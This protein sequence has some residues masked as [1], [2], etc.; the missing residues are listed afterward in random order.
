VSPIVLYTAHLI[1]LDLI[2]EIKSGEAYMMLFIAQSP[3]ASRAFYPLTSKY[4]PQHPVLTHPQSMFFPQVFIVVSVTLLYASWIRPC[5][6]FRFRINSR[7]VWILLD[8]LVEIPEGGGGGRLAHRKVSTYTAQQKTG[9]RR[10]SHTSVSG[11]G[12]EPTIEVF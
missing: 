12:F 6:L 10:L 11:V 4:F 9:R 3:P 2:S 8:I 5:G 1:L 7:K